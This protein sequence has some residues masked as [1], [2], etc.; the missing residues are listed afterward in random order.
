M[1]AHC[2]PSAMSH[3]AAI[4]AKPPARRPRLR[5][6]LRLLLAT[7]LC[8]ARGLWT[9]RARFAASLSESGELHTNQFFG[10]QPDI[11][12]NLAELHFRRS[13]IDGGR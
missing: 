1:P 5:F 4:P 8:L 6:T 10:S 12:S 3:T 7:F 13:P 9:H 2:S 11:A